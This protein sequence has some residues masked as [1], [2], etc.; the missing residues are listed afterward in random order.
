M[1]QQMTEDKG[2]VVGVAKYDEERH[3]W[4]DSKVSFFRLWNTL[5]NLRH[6]RS[7]HAAVRADACN[8]A[9][10]RSLFLSK[11]GLG[12]HLNLLTGAEELLVNRLSTAKNTAICFSPDAIIIEDR[13]P[14]RRLW[15]KHRVFYMET[16]RH[17]HHTH[18][19]RFRQNLW[20]LMPWLLL[21]VLIALWP[22]LHHFLPQEDI[23]VDIIT[24]LAIILAL[25]ALGVWIGN[26][27][28]AAHVIGYERNYYLT[29]PLFTLELPFWN[30]SALLS[31]RL[32][33]K[34]DFYKKFV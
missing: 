24:A 3:T 34:T 7:G 30:L 12:D 1:S 31:H 2:I 8:L 13:L 15:K 11:D 28:R 17:Q 23:A 10:R 26:W 20:L 21:M 5:A 19:F 16:R 18:L 14:A 22:L 29:L 27:N 6:V 33:S 25:V 32:S 4:F 9:L